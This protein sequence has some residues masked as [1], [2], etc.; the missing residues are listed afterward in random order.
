VLDVT[1]NI[2]FSLK[3]AL[4]KEYFEALDSYSGS[5]NLWVEPR[6]SYSDESGQRHKRHQ[7]RFIDVSEVVEQPRSMIIKGRQQYG[8]TS[9]ARYICKS[10]I[11]LPTPYYTLYL[12]ARELKPYRKNIK[13]KAEAVLNELELEFDNIGCIVL[14]EFS[15]SLQSADKLLTE[16]CEVFNEVPVIIMMTIVDNPLISYQV[17][18][19]SNRKF[20]TLYIWSLSRKGIRSFVRSFNQEKFIE[21]DTAVLNRVTADLD[22][23]NIPRT[24]LNCLTMLKI[25]EV[26]F[27]ESPVNRTEVIRRVLFLLFNVDNIPTYQTKPDVQ[28]VEY[29]LGYF[30]ENLFRNNNYIFTKQDFLSCINK[31]CAANQ[32]EIETVLILRVLLQN[33][34]IVSFGGSY[35][36][37]FSYWV[38]YFAAHRMHHDID[39]ANYMLEDHK[40][41]SYPEVMEFY[42]GIDRRRIDALRLLDKDLGE[43]IDVVDNKCSLEFD[44]K[45]Y[46]IAKWD[47]S[48]EVVEQ[49]HDELSEGVLNSNLPEEVK[50]QYADKYYDSNKPLQQDINGILE[51]YSLLKLMKGLQS[52]A[53]ALRNSDYAPPQLKADLLDRILSGWERVMKVLVVLSPVLAKERYATFSGA[54][55]HLVDELDGSMNEQ[56]MKLWQMLPDNIVNCEPYPI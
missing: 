8:L 24:P 16:L 4:T 37:K 30:C 27:D 41:V 5:N 29:I 9:L 21:N 28:D 50:D 36:F 46:D 23:L 52:G 34:I 49:L 47:P 15:S 13:K 39:F 54:S 20:D 2:L 40:Y 3:K 56:V 7:S 19:P 12:D 1:E 32:I 45:F 48:E 44:F 6:L 11:E 22:V 38:F 10:S 35:T 14:D 43:I 18:L 42:T 31:F 25:Y 33:N 55:F 51:E 53:R 26:D 17:E